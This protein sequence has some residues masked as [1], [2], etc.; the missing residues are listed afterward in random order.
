MRGRQITGQRRV[1][2]LVPWDLGKSEGVQLLADSAVDTAQTKV[3]DYWDSLF[4]EQKLVMVPGERPTWFT[5]SPLTTGQKLA[6]PSSPLQERVAWFLRC[7]LVKIDNYQVMGV[8]G[9][10]KEAEQPDRADR[11]P[12]VGEMASEDWYLRCQLTDE[13]KLGLYRMISHISEAQHPLSR[14]SA[15][16]PGGSGSSTQGKVSAE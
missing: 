9:V 2:L 14:P 1:V 8:D 13:D 12:R 6:A 3:K 5:I 10:T 4:D 16:P 15:M 11:G 7:G